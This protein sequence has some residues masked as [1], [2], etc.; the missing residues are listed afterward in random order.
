MGY[1]RV[2]MVVGMRAL[3]PDYNSILSVESMS[4][5]NGHFDVDTILVVW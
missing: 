2:S 3:C 4:V 1:S 5:R